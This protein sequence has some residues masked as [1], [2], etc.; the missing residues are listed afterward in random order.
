MCACRGWDVLSD[1][2]LWHSRTMAKNPL[3]EIYRGSGVPPKPLL[4]FYFTVSFLFCVWGGGVFFPLNYFRTSPRSF[5]K[6]TPDVILLLHFR[7]NYTEYRKHN[8]RVSSVMALHNFLSLVTLSIVWF[9][10]ILSSSSIYFDK[11]LERLLADSLL[12]S[13]CFVSVTFSKSRFLVMRQSYFNC[14]LL[15]FSIRC[16]FVFV[17][18]KTYTFHKCCVY[19][20]LS[21]LRL[22][23]SILP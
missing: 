15:I 21:V 17:F 14:P 10:T 20:S 13:V 22:N 7:R 3:L 1:L 5:P 6:N 11:F 16:F 9:L 23:R 19:N 4:S 8:W 2:H 12:F 18:I